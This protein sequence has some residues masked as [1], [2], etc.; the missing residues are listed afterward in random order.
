M[1]KIALIIS[2]IAL[3]FVFKAQEFLNYGNLCFAKM[4]T[5]QLF[6]AWSRPLTIDFNKD[7]KLDFAIIDKGS[8][9]LEVF[10]NDGAAKFTNIPAIKVYIGTSAKDLCIGDFDG[11]TY[12]DI[13]T[14]NAQG[15]LSLFKNL[16]GTG[17]SLVTTYLN[18]SNPNLTAYRIEAA[19]LNNDSKIDIIGSGDDQSTLNM[20]A[21]TFENMGPFNFSALNFFTIFG[22]HTMVSN[23]PKVPFA[24]ADFNGDN[25]NDFVIGTDDFTDTL[26]IYQNLGSAVISFSSP[27]IFKEP[28]GSPLT[29]IKATDYDGDTKPDFAIAAY[30]GFSINKNFGFFSFNNAYLNPVV[31]G[32]EF[33]IKD[34]DSDSKPDLV[35][36]DV[37]GS[38]SVVRGTTNIGYPFVKA[39]FFFV[40]ESYRFLLQNFDGNSIPD[41]VFAGTGDYPYLLNFRNFTFNLKTI[42]SST[43]TVVCPTSAV[44]LNSTINPTYAGNYLWYPVLLSGPNLNVTSA[45]NY[46]S[47]FSYTLPPAYGQCSLF[48]DTLSIQSMPT[49]TGAIVSSISVPKC[50]GESVD[51]N[52]SVVA[53]TS[54]TWSTGATTN[55]IVVTPMTT[56]VYTLNLDNG[57]PGME[58]FTVTVSPSPT[59]SITSSVTVICAGDSVAL[60]GNGGDTYQ[61][62]PGSSTATT[63][64]VN[65]AASTGYAVIGSNSFGCPDTAFVN[66]TVNNFP[67]LAITPS[68][69]NVC[70]GD[71]VTLT[72]NG[73]T[74][75]TWNTGSNLSVIQVTPNII[76]NSYS[77]SAGSNCISNASIVIPVKIPPFINAVASKPSV[78]SGDTVTLQAFGAA[79]YTWST[80]Q[81]GSTIVVNPTAST[82]YSVLGIG[83]NGCYNYTTV[84]IVV[85][86]GANP[87]INSSGELCPGKL[88]AINASGAVSYTWNTGNTNPAFTVVPPD[89]QPLSYTVT[90]KDANGC[91]GSASI[92]FNV[93]DK[94]KL[95]IYNG[96]TPNGDGRNDIFFLENIEMYPGNVVKIF[97]RWGQLLDEIYD[98]NNTTKFWAGTG[99]GGSQSVP[100]GTYYYVIDLKNGTDLIKGWIELTKKDLN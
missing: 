100:S 41:F 67:I 84:P 25:Y 36:A 74:T 14:I 48:G 28:F 85:N 2:F 47:V 11:D 82:T 7:G 5:I 33:D 78:C 49:P 69:P 77:V 80:I 42:I 89:T 30:S 45:G 58:T 24:V 72:V 91:V 10:F 59:V 94:C 54:F 3:S 18:S 29:S 51:L 83:T 61:W 37:G 46:N 88:V 57:C 40:G 93:S 38:F 32:V 79:S 81:F 26:E 19:D 73:A 63:I 6:T 17:L 76:V 15:D 9:S 13:A 20:L 65:P 60:T 64:V 1:K 86:A 71:S 35:M 23:T 96:I 44:T 99:Q 70:F 92:Q 97:N 50:P 52:A 90:T 75:Y 21:F 39:D 34:V 22:G 12:K 4:D 95:V 53:T 62:I 56:T 87:I 31:S 68:K 43:N 98:Y 66:I 8:D 55:T 27:V 16:T